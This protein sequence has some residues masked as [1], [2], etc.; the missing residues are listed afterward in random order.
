LP[1]RL[2]GWWGTLFGVFSHHREKV[3][4]I[5]RGK[6][7]GKTIAEADEVNKGGGRG[8]GRYGLEILRVY[9]GPELHVCRKRDLAWMV[10][11]V[12][13]ELQRGRYLPHRLT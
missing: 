8:V 2:V 13:G 4:G 11:E 12:M 1:F 3:G 5:A 7:C 10:E 6:K 9:V